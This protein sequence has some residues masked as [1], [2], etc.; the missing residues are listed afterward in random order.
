MTQPTYTPILIEG[1]YELVKDA[2]AR[3][4]D[5][6]EDNITWATFH[7]I[8][9]ERIQM[10]EK[11]P[12]LPEHHDYWKSKEGVKMTENDFDTIKKPVGL[13]A[14]TPHPTVTYAIPKPDDK[15]VWEEAL[16]NYKRATTKYERSIKR[17]NEYLKQNYNPP[18]P[19]K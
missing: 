8:W 1:K 3:K 5:T 15:D 13:S 17:Y 19:K 4:H 11:L 2:P 7:S 14:T 16:I 18:T 10:R 6:I 12:T 9:E